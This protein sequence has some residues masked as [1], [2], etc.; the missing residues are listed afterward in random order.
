MDKLDLFNDAVTNFTISWRN[1]F[2][3]V[4]G[5]FVVG[6]I[7]SI[8]GESKTAWII[9]SWI[10]VAVLAGLFYYLPKRETKEAD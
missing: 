6:T 9:I 10:V 7:F 4:A 1:I 2:T 8:A 3:F 5:I